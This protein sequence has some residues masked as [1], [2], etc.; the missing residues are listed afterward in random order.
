MVT[1]TIASFSELDVLKIFSKLTL[2]EG[3]K[4]IKTY[5]SFTVKVLS[6]SV[7]NLKM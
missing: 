6:L 3:F 4:L 1:A 2:T 5:S 7:V